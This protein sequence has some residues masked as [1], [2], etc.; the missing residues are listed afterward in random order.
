M[1][2]RIES[3]FLVIEATGEEF[4]NIGFGAGPVQDLGVID[5][6]VFAGFSLLNIEPGGRMCCDDC[7]REITAED[8]CYYVAVL[9]Q[10]MC[11]ECFERWHQSAKYYPEDVP[12]E[13]KNFDRNAR[14]LGLVA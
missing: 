14:K 1:A 3:K 2:R 4:M 5:G 13:E 10:V 8:T 6:G 12:Y 9:N 11:K 7:N